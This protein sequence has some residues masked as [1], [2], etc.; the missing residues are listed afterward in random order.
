MINPSAITVSIARCK[1]VSPMFS[2]AVEVSSIT[3]YIWDMIVRNVPGVHPEVWGKDRTDRDEGNTCKSMINEDMGLIK[4]KD[5]TFAVVS[6]T[7]AVRKARKI[8]PLKVPGVDHV[9]VP[10]DSFK[11]AQ[12]EDPTLKAFFDKAKQTPSG[13]P[14]K[15]PYFRKGV[16]C[17]D[18][19]RERKQTKSGHN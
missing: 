17:I 16:C 11:I 5:A 19:F 6:R 18:D 15:N 1:I 2:G 7:E 13:D 10:P 3:N 12:G 14:M 8:G 4:E 9:N